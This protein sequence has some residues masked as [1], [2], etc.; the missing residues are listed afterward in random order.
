M[1]DVKIE[2]ILV[3]EAEKLNDPIIWANLLLYSQYYQSFFDELQKKMEAIVSKQIL[4]LSNKE[5]MMQVEFWYVLVF[6]NCPYLSAG[7][8]QRM[9]DIIDNIKMTHGTNFPSNICVQ[10]VCDFLQ[11]QSAGG[12][13]PGESL[14]NWNGSS[15]FGDQITYRTYQRTIFKK[16]RKRTYGLYAS[17]D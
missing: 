4:Q 17:L 8:R 16:Y 7:L 3:Q 11:Q 5:P 6:H 1:L 14:F 10:L 13:K 12:N 15:N 9:S 2:N